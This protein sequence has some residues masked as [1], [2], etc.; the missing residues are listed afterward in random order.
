LIQDCFSKHFAMKQSKPFELG[1]YP[2]VPGQGRKT[3][4]LVAPLGF[5]LVE[6]L[7][8]IAI[9][10][11]LAVMLV[12]GYATMRNKTRYQKAR[13]FC[14]HLGVANRGYVTVYNRW[15]VVATTNTVP[16]LIEPDRRRTFPVNKA[17]HSLM[18][19][20]ASVANPVSFL[21]MDIGDFNAA[22]NAVDGWGNPY[23]M[24]FDLTGS[25]SIPHPFKAN[26]FLRLQTLAYTAGADGK[27]S[28]NSPYNDAVNK[29]NV[30][31]WDEDL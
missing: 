21:S 4:G 14:Q 27:I 22:G 16:A 28:T 6:L 11:V 1:F 5:T 30:I 19:V 23:L 26:Q 18:V 12:S 13:L 9:I 20:P 17:Y 8:V 24:M 31:S 25:N 3:T 2:S 29:D 10:T 15:P 7:L